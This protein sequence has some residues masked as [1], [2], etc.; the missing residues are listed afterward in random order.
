MDTA[1]APTPNK[2]ND[3]NTNPLTQLADKVS[4]YAMLLG[5]AN[6]V[7]SLGGI[8]L[9]TLAI[10]AVVTSGAELNI[11]PLHLLALWVI[12]AYVYYGLTRKAYA[13]QNDKS[14]GYVHFFLN[15]ILLGFKNT[16]LS[17]GAI[18]VAMLLVTILYTVDTTVV[19]VSL[20]ISIIMGVIILAAYNEPGMVAE[21]NFDFLCTKKWDLCEKIITERIAERKMITVRDLSDFATTHDVPV[22]KMEYLYAKYATMYPRRVKYGYFY[23]RE[24]SNSTNDPV[25]YIINNNNTK[26]PRK[27][28]FSAKYHNEHKDA[29]LFVP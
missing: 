16:W 3:P 20:F 8:V 12:T 21:R 19:I 11:T 28:L 25:D 7:I 14:N 1:P 24:N 2:T 15:D 9:S 23:Y 17:I 22:E 10:A 27:M 29:F 4:P 13:A 18:V 5:L 6:D 26:V